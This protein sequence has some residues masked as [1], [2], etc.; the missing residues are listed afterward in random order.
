MVFSEDPGGIFTTSP[1]SPAEKIPPRGYSTNGF[2]GIWGFLYWVYI[3]NVSKGDTPKVSIQT[4]SKPPAPGN[5]NCP[6]RRG[7][8][9]DGV[10][11]QTGA[12]DHAQRKTSHPRAPESGY[13]GL[14]HCGNTGLIPGGVGRINIVLDR[15]T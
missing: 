12:L 1:R 9:S 7:V 8:H 10:S 5:Q 6:F 13:T 4:V 15:R 11:I 2:V 3:P 14:N